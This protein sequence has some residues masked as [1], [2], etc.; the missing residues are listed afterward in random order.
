MEGHGTFP[1]TLSISSAIA[2]PPV[3]EL[4]LGV[5][6]LASDRLGSSRVPSFRF[7]RFV[8][9]VEQFAADPVE[10]L[11]IAAEIGHAGA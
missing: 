2:G 6:R 8:E 7:L 11:G 10:F 5:P 3:A 9:Q 1:G 4:V